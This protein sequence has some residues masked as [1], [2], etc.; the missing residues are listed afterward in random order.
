MTDSGVPRVPA[1]STGSLASQRHPCKFPKVPGRRRGTRGFPAAP[2]K[3]LEPSQPEGK[4]G[5]PRAN[6]RGRLRSP[7]YH[8]FYQKYCPRVLF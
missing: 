5:L 7:S 6:P 1:T 8:F 4:I 2:E 3:D